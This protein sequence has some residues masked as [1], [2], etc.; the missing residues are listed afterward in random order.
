MAAPT[1]PI[2]PAQ[3]FMGAAWFDVLPRSVACPQVPATVLLHAGPPFQGEPPAPVL[4]SAVQA[5]LFERLAQ[6]RAGALRLLSSGEAQLRPAQDHGVATPL[7][8]VV[9]ASMCVMAVRQGIHVGFAAMLE[10]P[11]PALRFGSTDPACGE[12]LSRLGRLVMEYVRPVLNAAPMPIADLVRAAVAAGDD[13]HSRTGRANE[14]LLRWLTRDRG[15]AL[16]SEAAAALLALPAFALPVLMAAA[17]AAL[18]HHHCAVEAL[19]GNGVDFGVR[20][21]GSPAWDRQ[22]ALPPI[23]ERFPGH[24][25][26]TALPAIGDSV[27]VDFCGLGGQVDETTTRNA[28]RDPDTG[29]LDVTRIAA[30]AT[31]PAALAP[32]F[33][34][35][36]LDAAGV[37]GLI[38]RGTY[39]AP[40]TV[41]SS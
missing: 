6:D 11:P 36:I 34:L 5:L 4:N 18:R 33:N 31:A 32:L 1:P 28:L 27:L 13:C 30:A 7:A 22:P 3:A 16:A 37:A 39:R 9:S 40:P 2:D 20:R 12:R 17:V 10:G 29:L 24:D 26:C 15:V 35:A 23:G 21:R 38:G 25:E 14:G 41:W 19:G 8:Q